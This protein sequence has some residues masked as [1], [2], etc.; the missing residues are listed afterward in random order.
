M[1]S[2]SLYGFSFAQG[3]KFLVLGSEKQFQQGSGGG[4]LGMVGAGFFLIGAFLGT[5]FL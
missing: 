1:T 2:G 5:F 3:F 4:G